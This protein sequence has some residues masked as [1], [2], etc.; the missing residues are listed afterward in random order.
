MRDESQQTTT[1]LPCAAYIYAAIQHTI[2]DTPQRTTKF[3]L[4]DN[5]NAGRRRGGEEQAA[6]CYS[7]RCA[8]VFFCVG[9]AARAAT[10][11]WICA[12]GRNRIAT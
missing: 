5:I 4:A 8:A 3:H 10:R 6:H 1:K 2:Q 9:P 7:V 11:V 12:R